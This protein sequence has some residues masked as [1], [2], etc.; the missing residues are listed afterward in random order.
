[1][2]DN[3]ITNQKQKDLRLQ[4]FLKEI[5]IVLFIFMAVF[6]KWRKVDYFNMNLPDGRVMSTI[7]QQTGY[8]KLDD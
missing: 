4:N 8:P 7:F 5:N 2:N 6:S 1:M 3:Q